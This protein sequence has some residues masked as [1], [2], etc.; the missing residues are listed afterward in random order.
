MA[1]AIP[2]KLVDAG[3][4]SGRL[5]EFASGDTVPLDNLVAALQVLGALTPAPGKLPYFKDAKTAALAS[6]SDK[7]VELLGKASAADM[8]KLLA[9]A[10]AGANKDITS[11]E[12]LTTALSIAQGG[13]GATDGATGLANLVGA[14]FLNSPT[15]RPSLLLD[16]VNRGTLD[17]RIVWARASTATCCG[18][19]GLLQ[20]VPANQPRFDHDP[21][22]RQRKGLLIEES[23][24][25]LVPY[26]EQPG[27]WSLTGGLVLEAAGL[28]PNGTLTAGKFV[29]AAGAATRRV[30]MS[31][32]ARSAG[33]TC[34]ASIYAKA[35]EFST[36]RFRAGRQL[37]EESADFDLVAS[38]VT[39]K[40]SNVS[41]AWLVPVGNG[42]FRLCIVVSIY[43]T[44]STQLL[45]LDPLPAGDGQS[46]FL[47]WGG[48]CEYALTH[49]SYM[50][51]PATWS[52][53]TSAATYFDSTGKLVT[54]AA[55]VARYG[56]AFDGQ[57]WI[58]RGLVA[59]PAATNVV[60]ASQTFNHAKWVAG[61]GGSAQATDNAGAAPDGT[62]TAAR[63]TDS[64][65]NEIQGIQQGLAITSSAGGQ[66]ASMFMK[67]GTSSIAS[68]RFTLSGGTSVAGEL[69]VN[70]AT[71]AALWR[72][73]VAGATYQ[74]VPA[75]GGWWR[76]S[77]TLQDN[78]SGNVNANL[79]VRP[80][81]A[82]VMRDTFD[83]AA[84][85]N[86]LVWGAQAE[87]GYVA[88]SYIPTTTDPVQRAADTVAS[89][90]TLREADYPYL[91][92][93]PW[94]NPY[95]GSLFAQASPGQ[96]NAYLWEFSDGTTANRVLVRA[97]GNAGMAGFQLV[98]NTT[99]S[100][101]SASAAAPVTLGA[102]RSCAL[103]WDR[104][105][106]AMVD[107]GA[108]GVV[109]G[110]QQPSQCNQLRLGHSISGGV[111]SWL[112]GHLRQLHYFPQRL[113]A[114]EL[115]GIAA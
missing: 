53:R 79:E 17:S 2:L 19:D 62:T 74:V 23:R 48:Q 93:G 68:L 66:T 104:G 72:G 110:T 84:T 16:F 112:N 44:N 59:E 21:I 15:V 73:G 70:L 26:S 37:L 115:Q 65:T 13:T 7:A 33:D 82:S 78:N 107:G 94:F 52:A 83:S 102:I 106:L 30:E 89:V 47:L 18:P 58:A 3:D 10:G 69:I 29:A 31:F 108:P 92:V 34:C 42:W 41:S 14:P 80:A 51:T 54:A 49:S 20:V 24:T 76:V 39:R 71:G 12:G 105:G 11:L 5:V 57:R 97:N 56:Y 50:P 81:W 101:G 113:S 25:N 100:A 35:A 103:G 109:T 36:I 87:A 63:I 43:A 61:A 27:R 67:A 91:P 46:G 86:I 55:G 96:A 75:G 1:D 45:A 114:A 22:T 4:G 111:T 6:L 60:L 77:L 28:A 99:W 88:T 64:V 98:G 8:L 90:A 9:A 85:G 40:G 95:E 32:G 38:T